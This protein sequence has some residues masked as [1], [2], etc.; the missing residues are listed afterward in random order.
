MATAEQIIAANELAWLRWRTAALAS[1]VPAWLAGRSLAPRQVAA[2]GWAP[3]W[4]PADWQDMTHRL[5]RHGV[6]VDVALR[7]GL[8]RRA[9]SGRL[10]DA[11]RGRV[12]L[13]IRR[14]SDGRILGFTARRIDDRDERVP[15]YVNSP[16][17]AAFKKGR[18]L[19]GGWE[20][21]ERL[22]DRI[23]EIQS[24]VVCE[25]PFDAVRIAVARQWAPVAACGT[26]LTQA[27]AEWIAR[28][29]T[30]F[31]RPIMLAY[32]G[33]TAGEA[34][35]WRAWD[36]LRDSGARA[37]CLGDLPE[38]RDP[39]E[40]KEDELLAALRLP[41]RRTPGLPHPV[42]EKETETGQTAVAGL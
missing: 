38:G 34:A 28:A 15:K 19:F 2:A 25:G 39:G 42:L 6:P 31:Q 32:D 7:A 8:I 41:E 22:S 4:A 3:G 16:T 9:E 36:L 17:N 40:L 21:R 37:L 13:P 27:Q 33:D 24:I 29:G 10:Y 14:P 35:T 26:A 23:D 1:P 11:F 12:V 30:F 18:V 5:R 20:A